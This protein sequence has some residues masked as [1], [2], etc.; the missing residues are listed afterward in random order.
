MLRSAKLR[1]W[2][3]WANFYQGLGLQLVKFPKT[4]EIVPL[5]RATS[6]FFLGPIGESCAIQIFLRGCLECL[7]GEI[8]TSDN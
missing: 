7:N 2:K 6:A 1:V 4:K 5:F 3:Q 8:Q